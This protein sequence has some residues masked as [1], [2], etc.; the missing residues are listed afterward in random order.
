MNVKTFI[1]N[2]DNFFFIPDID[3]FEVRKWI[4]FSGRQEDAE[5]TGHHSS[6]TRCQKTIQESYHF[7]G[8][9]S[10]KQKLERF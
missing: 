9:L 6:K 7:A 2:G 8:G 4:Y 3:K 1:W 10:Q 5:E